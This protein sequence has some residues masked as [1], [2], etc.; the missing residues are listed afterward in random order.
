MKY[1]RVDILVEDEA[2]GNLTQT[3]FVETRSLTAANVA[4]NT[5]KDD[6]VPF[7]AAVAKGNSDPDDLARDA[8]AILKALGFEVREIAQDQYA[9]HYDRF[10]PGFITAGGIQR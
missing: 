10:R 5:L 6:L 8:K 4:Y 2:T 9:V 7:L 1:K 3:K